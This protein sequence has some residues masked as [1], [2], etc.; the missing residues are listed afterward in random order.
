MSCNAVETDML[1]I[2][3]RRR[4]TRG[5]ACKIIILVVISPYDLCT[6]IR[7]RKHTISNTI[8]VLSITRPY[9]VLFARLSQ[10]DSVVSHLHNLSHAPRHQTAP[11]FRNSPEFHPCY[12]PSLRTLLATSSSSDKDTLIRRTIR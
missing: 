12:T 7:A 1:L 4:K 3:T 6:A 2:K 5:T 9:N 10:R 8:N 11:F